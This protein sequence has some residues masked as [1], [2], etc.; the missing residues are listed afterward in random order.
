[1]INKLIKQ[2]NE[3]LDHDLYF[4][5]LCTA[6]TL[7]DICGKAEYPNISTSERYKVW[8]NDHI[9][10]YEQS[11]D[12][13][14]P[15]LSGDVIYSLRNSLLHAGNPNVD[16][17]KIINEFILVVEKKNDFGAYYDVSSTTIDGTYKT[18][19]LS[20][21]RLCLLLC[22]TAKAYFDNNREK[23]TFFNY[24]IVQR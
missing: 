12:L 17:P 19:R 15:Y 22:K 8:Y 20:A 3:A 1:M 18:Y 6:L 5:A 24:K 2:I 7:P 14:Q 13:D 21:R 11:C 23:F 9:G 10:Q 16:N 4:V